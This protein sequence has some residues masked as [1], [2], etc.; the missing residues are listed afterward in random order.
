M[1]RLALI[2]NSF[3][4]GEWS[5][6]MEGRSDIAKYNS[7]LDTLVNYLVLQQGGVT[8]RAGTKWI[9]P[10]KF[11]TRRVRLIPF[12][13]S[14]TTAYMLEVGHEYIRFYRAAAR[15]EEA[16]TPIEVETPYQEE[17]LDNIDV[18]QAADVLYFFHPDYPTQKLERYGDLIWRFRPVGFTPP[19]SF[20]FGGRPDASVTPAAL[21]GTGITF[22]GVPVSPATGVFVPADVGRDILVTGG[23]NGGARATITAF[24]DATHVVATITQP[25]LAAGAVDAGHW[26]LTA[27]PMA[28][29][30]PA[31]KDP[32]GKP[33]VTLTLAAGGWRGGINGFG[34]DSDCGRFAV[35]N[36]GMYE[37]TSVTSAT[38]AVATIRGE[39]SAT[40]PAESDTWSL[41]EALFSAQNGYPEAGTFFEGRLWLLAGYRLAGS[42]TGD[43]EN[44]GVGV[45]DDDAVIFAIQS[46]QVNAG[47]WIVGARALLV[48]TAGA[49]YV[50][51]GGSGEAITP[52]NI[53]VTTQT[54]YGS[55]TVAPIRVSNIVCFLSRSKRSLRELVFNFEVDGYVAPD[56]LLLA[57]HLT[58]TATIVDLAYQQDPNSTI[59]AV[60]SDGVGLACTYLRDQN[61]VA[62]SRQVTAGAIEAVGVI[63]SPHADEVYW[64][65]Q[66]T[67][68][69]VTAR[70]VEWIGDDPDL[71]YYGALNTDAAV[72]YRGAAATTITGLGHLEGETVQIVGDGAVYPS[73]VVAGGQV[74][75]NPA[76]SVVEVGLGYTSTLTTLRPEVNAGSGSAQPAKKRWV[77]IHARL[78]NSLGMS[79]NGDLMPFRTP[80]H[81]MGQAVPTFTGDKEVP[82]LGYG[83][84]G[85]ITLAQTQ[86]LP[87]TVLMLTGVLDLGGT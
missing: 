38:V 32:A 33:G 28:Q 75:I 3:S 2:Q 35:I 1:P 47:K 26:Q 5:P 7:A 86:P 39:A 25:F 56:L 59:W 11:A 17:A 51:T 45:L 79:I 69:G 78:L 71:G 57:E 31:A 48:G 62:W 15:L 84:D 29:V 72:V 34:E 8:R 68:N 77:T 50:A 67:L 70:H 13:F 83:D 46:D 6:Q 53:Q 76:A 9:A 44:F 12:E 82:N 64:A 81:F 14:S 27:S 80:T 87:S 10:T 18:R 61:V 23:V 22:T 20:E 40:T 37:I 54:T 19:P 52:S 4:A 60:R 85:K 66:R 65:V 73:Q 74:V 36:G 41:E 55:S 21:T 58:K 16:G 43:F 63:P 30:T 24:T 49:E 42:K